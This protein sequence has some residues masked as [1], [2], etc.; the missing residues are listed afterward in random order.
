MN[1]DNQVDSWLNRIFTW[2]IAILSITGLLLA[3]PTYGLYR[4]V[5]GILTIISI[6]RDSNLSI[7]A[8]LDFTIDCGI[9]TFC[10]VIEWRIIRFCFTKY[11]FCTDGIEASFLRQTPKLFLWDDFQEV[12]IC[13]EA[14]RTKTNGNLQKLICFIRKGEKKNVFGHWKIGAFWRYPR[15]IRLNY[16]PELLEEIAS[17]CPHTIVDYCK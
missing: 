17:F 13:Y 9:C 15:I 4:F 5:N 7:G 12:C 3:M 6:I 1:D 11:Y 2:I 16:T 14:H 8:I 10:F